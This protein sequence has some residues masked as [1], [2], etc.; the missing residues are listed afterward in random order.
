MSP[1]VPRLT[2]HSSAGFLV[3]AMLLVL[4]GPGVSRAHSFVEKSFDQLVAEAEDV[5]IGTVT[6]AVASR[7]PS[8][9][10]VTDVALAVREVVKGDYARAAVPVRVVG[11]TVG[12]E[13]LS[14]AGF[15][16]FTPGAT[17]LLFAKGNGAV[18]LPFVGGP[19]GVFKVTRDP[20]TQQERV[21]GVEELGDT[22]SLEEFLDAIRA[23]L[24]R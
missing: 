16:E 22:V 12:N 2:R 23:R 20:A 17:Y 8:G 4:T 3:W 1:I 14:A 15:P 9:L 10:I 21:T 18:V 5:F 6:G 24:G 11:G 13:T 19:Q 7:L